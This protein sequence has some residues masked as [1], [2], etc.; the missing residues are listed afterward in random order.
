MLTDT[1]SIEREESSGSSRTRRRGKS[2]R[3]TGNSRKSSRPDPDAD[4]GQDREPRLS[5]LDVLLSILQS[6]LGEIRDY[7]AEVSFYSH[8]NGLVVLISGAAICQT[9]KQIHSGETCPHC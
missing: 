3:L 6:D 1:E 7:G 9:H 4:A 2:D 8:Q 5:S